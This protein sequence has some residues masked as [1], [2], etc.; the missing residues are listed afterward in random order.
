MSL[1][2][3]PCVNGTRSWKA[4]GIRRNLVKILEQAVEVE[5]QR[6]SECPSL[7]RLSACG[8]EEDRLAVLSHVC[9]ERRGGQAMIWSAE[10]GPCLPQEHQVRG[11]SLAGTCPPLSGGCGQRGCC[12]RDAGA[13]G[14]PGLWGHGHFQATQEKQKVRGGPR[15]PSLESH[16]CSEDAGISSLTQDV[17]G[18]SW[19]SQ[20]QHLYCPTTGQG[21]LS[22]CASHRA[23]APVCPGADHSAGPEARSLAHAAPHTLGFP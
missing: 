10:Q 17:T 2:Q 14:T 11:K 20:H 16:P 19:V 15:T 5:P 4:G 9:E 1:D 6:Q 13:T 8:K 3:L 23:G 7:K 18:A 21:A 12:G 22:V